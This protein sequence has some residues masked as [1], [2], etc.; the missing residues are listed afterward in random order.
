MHEPISFDVIHIFIGFSPIRRV[1]I[2]RFFPEVEEFSQFCGMILRI[3]FK[4][5]TDQVIPQL[6]VWRLHQAGA[7]AVRKLE[8]T[9]VKAA[10]HVVTVLHM[11][12][13]VSLDSEDIFT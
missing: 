11:Q 1:Q 2:I 10:L 3:A 4:S 7:V 9:V 12:Q 6:I 13:S 5:A 8:L